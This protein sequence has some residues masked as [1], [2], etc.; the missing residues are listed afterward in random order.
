MKAVI[1][2]PDISL[3]ALMALIPAPDFPTGGTLIGSAEGVQHAYSSGRGTMTLRATWH[4]E[5]DERRSK[6][7]IVITELP[8][9]ARCLPSEA[10]GPVR[11]SGR[12]RSA[13]RRGT[14]TRARVSPPPRHPASRP[15]PAGVQ[16]GADR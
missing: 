15:P 11:S 5:R 2:D 12:S 6:E 4:V 13:Q 7:T 1:D 9:Q 10:C 3:A 14:R 16:G 8:Y